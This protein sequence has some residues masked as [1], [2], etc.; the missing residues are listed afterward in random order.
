MK[1]II[2]LFALSVLSLLAQ[3][4]TMNVV[5]GN[6]TWQFPFGQTGEMTFA[7][8]QTL[9]VNGKTFDI[10]DIAQI[11]M[12][13]TAV[14]DNTV[15][16]SYSGSSATVLVAGNVA[17]FVEAGVDG[18]HVFLQQSDALDDTVGEITY[19]LSGTSQDGELYLSGS[20]KTMLELDGLVLTN[21]SGAALNIQ[22]GKRVR[23]NVKDG[24]ENIL[25][26][27]AGG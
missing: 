24:T 1:K 27:C 6:I 3:A 7:D 14:E 13:Q 17:R 21:P 25:A 11:Y 10:D 16:V 8:G 9:T 2:L 22:N 4:Q 20:Y 23:I 12:D 18:A 19:T 26:D 5:T 15:K